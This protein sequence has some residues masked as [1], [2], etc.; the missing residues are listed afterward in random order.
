MEEEEFEMELPWEEPGPIVEYSGQIY[1]DPERREFFQVRGTKTTR[2]WKI[3]PKKILVCSGFCNYYNDTKTTISEQELPTKY[4]KKCLKVVA[5]DKIASVHYDGIGWRSKNIVEEISKAELI[6]G[7]IYY[8]P[9]SNKF[10]QVRK[11]E[12]DCAIVGGFTEYFESA[13]TLTAFTNFQ[14]SKEYVQG[15]ELVKDIA[16]HAYHDEYG[17]RVKERP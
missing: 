9:R 5:I 16:V 12:K 11:I 13:R 3:F 8:E 1:Y 6:E 7:E 15:C 2:V 10:F 14:L 4:L 17:W